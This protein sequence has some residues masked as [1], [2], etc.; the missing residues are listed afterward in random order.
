M[1]VQREY[2]QTHSSTEIVSALADFA[3]L[4]QQMLVAS[5][6]DTLEAGATLLLKRLLDLWSM[7]QGALLLATHSHATSKQSF[8]RSLSERNMLRVLARHD[9]D[10]DDLFLLIAT[11]S[12]DEDIQVSSSEPNWVVCQQLLPVPGSPHQDVPLSAASFSAPLSSTQSFFFL[13]RT[14]M[15]NP[16][17]RQAIVEK[18]QPI[19]LS[20]ANAVGSVILSLLQ[21]E[22]MHELET[23]TSQHDLQQMELLKAELLATVSHELRSPLASIKGYTATLLRHERR[24]AREEQ[25]EFLLAIHDASQRMETVIDRLLEMSQLETE[26][27]PLQHVPVDLVSVVREV[28]TARYQLSGGACVSGTESLQKH[29]SVLPPTSTFVLHIEDSD[30]N[31]TNKVPLVQADRRLVR[32]AVDHLLENAVLYSP[33]GGTV[34][35]GLRTREPEQIR[36]LSLML[37]QTPV[38]HRRAI[39]LPPSWP[40][41]QPMVEIWIQDHGI[42][43]AETHLEQIFQRFYRVDTSLTRTV[44][45][46]GLGLAIC[47]QIVALHG[48]GLWA[49]SEV[50]KGSSFHVLLPIDGH[51]LS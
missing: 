19:W 49:E 40:R 42:G 22:H 23:T 26:T 10:D 34:E 32:E 44:N 9:L 4:V 50:G 12:G 29:E 11:C 8:W 30:G 18:S 6:H 45:G 16:P 25:Q 17:S 28:I 35:V 41:D 47:K 20:V 33:E 37:V 46:L 36:Q 48:G 38:A 3:R 5:T 1:D 27:L 24:I 7:E 15:A 13:G 51:L 2:P 43:I 21:A 39:V 31:P 14:T